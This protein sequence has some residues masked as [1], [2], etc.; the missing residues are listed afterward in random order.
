MVER[1]S[2]EFM[3]RASPAN[4]NAILFVSGCQGQRRNKS[5]M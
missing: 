3:A 2:I 4:P 1:Q 5:V